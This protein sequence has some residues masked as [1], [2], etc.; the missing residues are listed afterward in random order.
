MRVALFDVDGTLIRGQ[1]YAHLLRWLWRRGWRR[2]RVLGVV[3]AGLPSQLGRKLGLVDRLHNQERWARGMAWLLRDAPVAEVEDLLGLFCRELAAA[4]RPGVREEMRARRAE[5]Y[6]IILASTGISPVIGCLA[7]ALEARGHAA[8]PL[9]VQG[10][11]FTGRLAGPVCNAVR[12]LRYVEE[13][14]EA[15]GEP[16]DWAASF[17][18]SDGVPDLPMLERVGHPVAVDPDSRLLRIAGER[19]WRVIT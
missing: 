2:P 5:G 8:T 19:N 7:Q 14:A 16:I 11:R 15:W 3:C 12:K 1:S 9:E 6:R 10:G 13:L 17:A 18:Y 4:L